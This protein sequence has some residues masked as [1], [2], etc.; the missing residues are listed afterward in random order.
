VVVI[1]DGYYG[2]GRMEMVGD[3]ISNLR[4]WMCCEM[5]G[6]VARSREVLYVPT[7]K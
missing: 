5:I 2:D 4:F 7:H 6:C 3:T 1:D